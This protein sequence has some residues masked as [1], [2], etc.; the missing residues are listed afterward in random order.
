METTEL[1][2]V[3][4]ESIGNIVNIIYNLFFVYKNIILLFHDILIYI[5][6]LTSHS[7]VYYGQVKK[8]LI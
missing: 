6:C 4:I 7:F 8:W 3:L 5:I 1:N 2:G